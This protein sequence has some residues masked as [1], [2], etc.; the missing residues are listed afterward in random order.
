LRGNQVGF[1]GRLYLGRTRKSQSTP[2][3]AWHQWIIDGYKGP[4]YGVAT[5][6]DAT[7]RCVVTPRP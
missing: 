3:A 1:D 4:V 7:V 5:I 2:I 6:P